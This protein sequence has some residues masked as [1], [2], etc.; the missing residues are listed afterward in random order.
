MS[1]YYNI[2]QSRL[3]S[4]PCAHAFNLQ[5]PVIRQWKCRIICHVSYRFYLK[6]QLLG[7]LWCQINL[8]TLSFPTYFKRDSRRRDI[9]IKVVKRYEQNLWMIFT[10]INGILKFSLTTQ[11]ILFLFDNLRLF[12]LYI[13]ISWS[14]WLITFNYALNHRSIRYSFLLSLNSWEQH[15]YVYANRLL[16]LKSIMRHLRLYIHL[17]IPLTF[18]TPV[19]RVISI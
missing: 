11:N 16:T 13:I 18:L 8:L 14:D 2:L 17:L 19:N 3:D 15:L 6:N 9:Y 1:T 10:L 4:T 12:F 5:Q 7:M